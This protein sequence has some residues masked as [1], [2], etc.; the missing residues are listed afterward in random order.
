MKKP[1]LFPSTSGFNPLRY[2]R[3][4]MPFALC[5]LLFALCSTISFATVRYVS[6]SGTSTPPYTTWETA[7]DSIMS[8]INISTF[9]DTIYVANGVYEEQVV[10]IPGL[11][12]IGNGMDSCIIDTHNLVTSQ[13]FASVRIADS[14][15]LKGFHIIIY[16][17]YDKGVGIAMNISAFNSLITLNNI[18]NGFE[19]I[20][21]GNKPYIYNNIISKVTTGIGLFN[22]NSVVRKN[23][24]YTDPNSDFPIVDGIEI[25]AFDYTYKPL[26]DSNIIY[27]LYAYGIHKSFGSTPTI[28]NNIIILDSI[29][30][31][32]AMSLYLSD[33]VKVFNNLILGYGYDGIYTEGGSGRGMN[34]Y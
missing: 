24:I 18:S 13:N 5:A 7:A 8:A 19:G 11:S 2:V 29:Y 4:S 16:N 26:I 27:P 15:L 14:C 9:G 20:Y 6:H 10:M 25:Q 32:D 28:S 3:C 21:V 22:S 30:S 17:N 31:G 34:V 1:V 33:T 12:L 23:T